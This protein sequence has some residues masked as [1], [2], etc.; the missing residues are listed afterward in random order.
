[1]PTQISV[2][3]VRGR[4]KWVASIFA[5]VETGKLDAFDQYFWH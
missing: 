2:L 4:R 3:G 1:M 5:A